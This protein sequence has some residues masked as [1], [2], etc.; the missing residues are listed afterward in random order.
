MPRD[1]FQEIFCLLHVSHPDPSHPEKKID[2][3]HILRSL[4]LTKFQ[5][6]FNHPTTWQTMVGFRGRVG[7]TQYTPKKLVKWGI[8]SFTLADT[9]AG[10]MLNIV[11]YTGALTL[12]DA[13]PQF[14]SLL[15][16]S[17]TVLHPIW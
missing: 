4:L 2:K 13:G 7:S 5:E 3:I 1:H 10:Y 17:R 16:L 9:N 14:A 6:H 11:V 12:D 8:M 15:V